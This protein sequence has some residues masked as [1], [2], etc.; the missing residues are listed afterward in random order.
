MKKRPT[1]PLDRLERLVSDADRFGR[2]IHAETYGA[3]FRR[4]PPRAD[5]PRRPHARGQ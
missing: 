1:L 5:V 3:R 4:S 2:L